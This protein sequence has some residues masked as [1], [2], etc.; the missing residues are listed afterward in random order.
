M[1]RKVL[2]STAYLPPLEYM[3]EIKKSDEV[4]IELE[5]NYR[6]QTYRNRCYINSADKPQ[7]LSVP[8]YLGSVHKTLVKDLRIDYTKRWQQVH[9]GAL[10]ASYGLSPYFIYYF[11]IFEKIISSR[12]EF[13]VDLNTELLEAILKMMKCERSITFTSAFTVPGEKENDLRYSISPKNSSE[14]RPK[15]YIPAFTPGTDYLKGLSIADLVFNTGPDALI[16]L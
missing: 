6:K 4:I 5:E 10:R 7:F 12:K 1:S 2:L 14:Y 3:A 15:N 11:E 8:V 13:L 16:Y 9:L